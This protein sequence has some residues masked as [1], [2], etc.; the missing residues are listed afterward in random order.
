MRD[1]QDVPPSLRERAR[2]Y[3]DAR[4]T[5]PVAPTRDASTVV[6]LRDAPGGP[7]VYLL[8][9]A[10]TMAFAAGMHVFLLPYLEQNA[11]TPIAGMA[12]RLD[13]L[14]R[15]RPPLPAR[16][17]PPPRARIPRRK[18]RA[19]S[20]RLLDLAVRVARLLRARDT[21]LINLRNFSSQTT[22][23]VVCC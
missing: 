5:A 4:A 22:N 1:V 13:L 11:L 23:H 3:L 12:H 8:R 2:A 20:G 18:P 16:T 19:L 14:P 6:L 17:H 9:R 7:E 10:G 15:T 21:F